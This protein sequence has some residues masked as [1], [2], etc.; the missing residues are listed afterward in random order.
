MA[1][2]VALRALRTEKGVD[3]DIQELIRRA[4]GHLDDDPHLANYI[5]R[6]TAEVKAADLEDLAWAFHKG[7][8]HKNDVLG[9]IELLEKSLEA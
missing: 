1:S 4:R 3:M 8:P 5:L 9:L 7:Q 6:D 2:G